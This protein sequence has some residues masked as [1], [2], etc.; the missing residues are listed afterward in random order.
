MCVCVCVCVR[1]RMRIGVSLLGLLQYELGSLN[2]RNLSSPGSGSSKSEF[3]VWAGLVLLKAE[4]QNVSQ[5]SLP[6]SSGLLAT[7]C[8]SW[9]VEASPHLSSSSHVVLCVCVYVSTF[10]LC[11]R[12][13]IKVDEGPS[14]SSMMSHVH[15]LHL[16][17]P[18][19]KDGSV[20]RSWWSG[21]HYMNFRGI[22]FNPKQYTC[23]FFLMKHCL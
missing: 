15:S 5:A 18:I 6:A 14:R 21:P 3:K 8:V 12:T 2:H 10:P 4:R 22:P 1:V 11:I 13:P 23:I 17:D 7:L 20:L 19:S 16:C 9:L